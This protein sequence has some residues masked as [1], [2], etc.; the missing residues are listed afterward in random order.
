M[1][2]IFLMIV[3]LFIITASSVVATPV[4]LAPSGT[5]LSTGQVHAEA[6]LSPSNDN[7]KYYW[8]GTGFMQVEANVISFQKPEGGSENMYNV[9]WNFLPE[10]F[11]TPA[12][13]FGATD[14]ASE[15]AEGIGAYVV[16]TKTL[17]T[18]R[19]LPFLTELRGTAGVGAAGIN[20]LFAGL[21]AGLPFN[22][23]V[24][25]EYYNSDFNGAIG[26]QPT[27]M[28]RVK[29]YEIRDEFYFGA[30]LKPITF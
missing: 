2:N 29:A 12:L 10:T 3:A 8:L 5:T 16:A 19:F 1:R 13:A 21:E 25:A 18:G 20:G 24:Q 7:G 28:F 26:W 23:F 9:Q 6:A 22:L 17:K 4:I 14:L 11:A 30:E 27:K 15:T